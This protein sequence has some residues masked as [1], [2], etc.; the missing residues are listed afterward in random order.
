MIT[1]K[2]RKKQRYIRFGFIQNT[3]KVLEYTNIVNE[4]KDKQ[5]EQINICSLKLQSYISKLYHTY[6]YYCNMYEL[7]EDFNE[8]ENY[9]S[10][11]SAC[12][13]NEDFKMSAENIIK[14]GEEYGYHK[15]T[16]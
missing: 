12:L 16:Q 2:I 3:K 5:F 15:K 10:T 8:E 6:N 4:D 11:L 13:N 9:K 7:K 1:E 14:I